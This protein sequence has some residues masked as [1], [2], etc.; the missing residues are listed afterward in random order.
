MIPSTAGFLD[1]DFE[2]RQQPSLTYKMQPDENLVRGHVDGLEAVRQAIYKIIM[3]ERYQYIIYS[4][5]YG[6]ELLDLFGE[7]VTYV[8]PELERRISEALLCDDR[9]QK[10]DNFEFDLSRKG[11]VHV[12]FIAHTIFGDVQAEREVNF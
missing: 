4:W 1:K 12:I 11:I 3:T 9:I 10:V 7:P 2:I 5:N 6:I 8:C